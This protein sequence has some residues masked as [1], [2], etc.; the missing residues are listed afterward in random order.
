MKRFLQQFGPRLV[1]IP[2]H[3]YGSHFDRF[4]TFVYKELHPGEL[5]RAA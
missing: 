1:I 3:N 2:W 5:I 4:N